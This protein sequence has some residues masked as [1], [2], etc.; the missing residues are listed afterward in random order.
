MGQSA[1][2][3]AAAAASRL[4]LSRVSS[5]W[6]SE[7]IRATSW[8]SDLATFRRIESDFSELLLRF[9]YA[10][11]LMMIPFEVVYGLE[12]AFRFGMVELMDCSGFLGDLIDRDV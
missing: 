8:C 5:S 10:F 1:A 7:A 9:L 4:S 11:L 3:N 2:P 6:A 12:V